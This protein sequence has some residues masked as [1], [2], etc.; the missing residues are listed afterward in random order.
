MT[1]DKTQDKTMK[2]STID[3]ETLAKHRAVYNQMK[4]RCF[5]PNCE[6]YPIYGGRG[7]TVC[8]R[9]KE[10]FDAFMEDMGPR[11]TDKHEID[12]VDN[13]GNYEPEN[14]EWATKLE[15]QLNREVSKHGG[16]RY[17]EQK[18]H[19]EAYIRLVYQKIHIGCYE[20]EYEARLARDGA[21]KIVDA[22]KKR[23]LFS[24]DLKEL[25]K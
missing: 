3:K 4:Q 23:G 25:L 7:I 14:C 19:W 10:S 13:N 16:V 11:P 24:L 8:D 15:Q 2:V 12:R 5:N 18:G 17:Y 1:L 9:W 6:R 20:T 22:L 21:R